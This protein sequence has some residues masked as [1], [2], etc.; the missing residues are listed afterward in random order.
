MIRLKEILQSLFEQQDVRPSFDIPPD[1][2]FWNQYNWW[3]SYLKSDMYLLRLHKEFPTYTDKQLRQ[4]R[5]VRLENLK[6]AK[7]KMHFVR[8]IGQEPGYTLGM[9]YP[10]QYKGEYWDYATKKWK[11]HGRDASDPR[12]RPGH[13]YFEREYSPMGWN[14]YPGYETIPAHEMGHIVDDGGYRIPESTII[15]IF[16]YTINKMSDS[17]LLYMHP[18]DRYTT[19][20]DYEDKKVFNYISTPTEFI[21]RIQP[22]RYM[23]NKLGIYDARK[24]AFTTA[25]YDKMIKSPEIKNNQHYQDIFDALKGSPAEKKKNFIDIMNSIAEVPVPKSIEAYTS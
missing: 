7:S 12:D 23:L 25:D 15:K 19:P 20:S 22:V 17:E 8:S 9:V 13:S 2:E 3:I 24:R 5:D 16:N 1:D 11:K 6:S 21:N 4:E 18:W 14:P 10:K